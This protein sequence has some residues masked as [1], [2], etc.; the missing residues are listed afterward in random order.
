MRWS[1][2]ARLTRAVLARPELGLRLLGQ[3]GEVWQDGRRMHRSMQLMV[4]LGE[5][6]RSQPD[7]P[8]WPAARDEMRRLVRFSSPVPTAV[9][10]VDRRIA[11]PGGDLAVRVYRPWAAEGAVPGILYAHGGGY[12]V[13]DLESHDP[14]CRYL[15]V[16]SGCVVVAVDYRLA[17][18]H[19][20][21]AAVEDAVAAYR[22][23][24]DNAG[25]VG[26]DPAAV[27]VMGDS[28]GGNLA[29]VLCLEARRVGLPQPRAQCLIY[30][31]VDQR[32]RFGS[33][34][35]FAEGFGLTLEGVELYQETYFPPGTDRT[36][37]RASPLCAESLAG[38]APALVLTAGFDVLRDDGEAY[39]AAL[40]GAGVDVT[41]RCADD[42]VHGFV[43]LL[44]IPDAASVTRWMAL[45]FTRMLTPNAMGPVAN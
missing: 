27:G 40:A 28:A 13:G 22:W 5:R 35:T 7:V 45:E 23:L 36:E 39:A 18:E 21:P 30:P 2:A 26:I 12:A 16:V 42:M 38:L 33:Y 9:H 34:A 6:F 29:A 11:G 19:P 20:Y 41:Y 8:D 3:R 43:N 17:P 14:L 32:L 1:F 25:Q 15:A 24:L 4:A 37:P 31:L 44:A 10:V